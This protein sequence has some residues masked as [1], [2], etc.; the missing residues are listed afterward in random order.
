LER[1]GVPK[2]VSTRLEK[3]AGDLWSAAQ[4]EADLAF[5][6]DR[7]RFE[8][9]LSDERA[10]RAETLAMAD[11]LLREAAVLTAT[12]KDLRTQITE[13]KAELTATRQH[14][15]AVRADQFWDRVVHDIHAILPTDG[16]MSA[17]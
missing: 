12:A 9:T 8:V 2:T 15:Q 5:Q 4:A 1:G 6:A 11:G 7:E 16:S 17:S 10:L 13:L 14:L 3:A